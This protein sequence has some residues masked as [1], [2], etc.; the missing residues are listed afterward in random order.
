MRLLV[1]IDPVPS[2]PPSPSI[3]SGPPRCVCRWSQSRCPPSHHL[4]PSTAVHHGASAGG[5]RP[6]ALPPTIS[7]HPQRSTTVRLLVVIDPVPSLPPSPSTHSGP[8]RCVCRWSQT[9]CPPSHHLPP[10]TA[11]HHGASAGGHRPGALPPTISLHPQR[12]TTVRLP[13]VTEPVP[14]LPPSPSIHSGPPRCVC[15]WSQTRCPPSHHLPPSTAVH[16]GASAGGDR[17]GALPP[18]ISLH[19]QRST[20]VRLLVVTD[21]VPSLPPSPSTHS[22]PPRC[23]CWWSQTRCPPSHHLPPST[24]V[25]HGASAGGHRPGALPPTISLHPQRSTTV[26]LLVVTDPVPSLPPSPSIHSGP[27]RCACWWSQTRRP[28]SHHLPPSTAVHHGASAGGHRP[29]ALPPTISLHPQRS[30][31]VRLLVVTD[32]AP[33]LP[34]SPSIHSGPPRCVCWW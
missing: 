26:R 8:P 4:P 19:P 28:P 31:T 25:H 17:P 5:H 10:P 27:P 16:H 33:S 29:G 13:V 9:R 14:S 11:V 7:L 20:T 18:T 6:G 12:S 1:V 24:A 30:T 3:H 22:G 23:V 15:R 21:P 2:L 32:P 34:P